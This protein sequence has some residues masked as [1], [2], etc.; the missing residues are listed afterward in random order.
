[1]TNSNPP[2]FLPRFLLLP[3]LVASPFLL[4]FL[5]F[6]FFFFVARILA[7]RIATTISATDFYLFGVL[8]EAAFTLTES[9]SRDRV[10][11]AIVTG[12]G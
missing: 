3:L 10:D 9:K 11:E 5:L 6:V 1:M 7:C 2:P 4:G 8:S 12:L